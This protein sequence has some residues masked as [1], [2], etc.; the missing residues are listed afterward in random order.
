M[1]DDR[2]EIRLAART[3]ECDELRKLRDAQRDQI[4]HLQ[5]ALRAQIDLNARLEKELEWARIPQETDEEAVRALQEIRNITK[6]FRK[7]VRPL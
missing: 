2:L 7:K 4:K 6:P 3:R 1:S 5:T